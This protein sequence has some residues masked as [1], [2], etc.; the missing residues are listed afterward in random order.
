MAWLLAEAGWQ[1][2][3]LEAAHPGAGSSGNPLAL[4]YPKLVSPAVMGRHLQSAAWLRMLEVLADPRLAPAYRP[5]GVLW[6][7]S[8]AQPVSQ[9]DA[10]HPWWA[11]EVWR[12]DADAASDQAGLSLPLGGLWLPRAGLIDTADL[13]RRLLAHPGIRLV[14]GQ[15]V[16]DVQAD[17]SGWVLETETR[18]WHD[19][20]V[21]LAMS[22]AASALGVCQGLPLRPVRGQLSLVPEHLALRTTLCYGGYLTPAHHGLHTLG[23]TFQPGRDDVLT[24]P[25]DD[26]RNRQALAGWLP[27]LA[28]ALPETVRWQQR[29]SLRWQTPDFLPLAGVLPDLRR[30]HAELALIAPGKPLKARGEPATL[31]VTL[32]HG[33]KG[34]TQAWLAAARIVAQFTEAAQADELA[35]QMEPTRFLRKRWKRGEL[36]HG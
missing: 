31:A 1:V 26:E 18:R 22:G 4:A 19:Q 15:P 5:C 17:P 35:E 36:R 8:A 29:A 33:A 20:H 3:V 30:L 14:L 23:A 21:V 9:V 32:A 34:Y 16:R 11:R 10:S 28:D 24:D 27:A 25:Q 6:L 12:L 7:E 2:T 13:L